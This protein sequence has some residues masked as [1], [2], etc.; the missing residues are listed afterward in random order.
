LKTVLFDATRESPKI[1]DGRD[2]T[3]RIVM[4][5]TMPSSPREPHRHT[6]RGVLALIATSSWLG[7]CMLGTRPETA[8]TSAPR[9]AKISVSYAVA[10]PEHAALA[11]QLRD[12]FHAR[13][14]QIE[15][16]EITALPADLNTKMLALV[17]AGTPPD[18]MHFSSGGVGGA[19]DLAARGALHPLDVLI[20]RDP[21]FSWD[22][23]WPGLGM[24]G[25]F[26]G[27][28]V[29]LPAI[30]L[31]AAMTFYNREVF[32]A[33]GRLTPD[34]HFT[35]GTWSWDTLIDESSKLTKRIETNSSGGLVHESGELVQ[36]GL[37]SPLEWDVHT[38]T[39]MLLRSYGA[40]FLSPDGAKVVTKTAEASQA[41]RVAHEL[42]YRRR[43][44]PGREEAKTL[45]LVRAGNL[46]Q[47]IYWSAATAWW[48][49]T[50]LD[51]DIAPVP[52]GP[53]RHASAATT[54]HLAL[55]R[56]TKA[57]DAAWRYAM[58]S[59]SPDADVE[60][61]SSL[62]L[63]T[64]RPTQFPAWRRR[65][66]AKKPRNIGLIELAARA[67]TVTPLQRPHPQAPAV[68]RLLAREM[69]ALLLDGKSPDQVADTL[70][71]EGNR[72]LALK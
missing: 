48:R 4:P 63:V 32:A 25:Q 51:W 33:A 1:L 29:A 72:L 9:P 56:D 15:L 61:A 60:R 5:T 3:G 62:G 58:V 49:T 12:Q 30:G 71:T 34:E 67:L 36:A 53:T 14:P 52:R 10:V 43:T 18:A 13:Y 7:G 68:E 26:E 46:A 22:D 20:K 6:R 2:D 57:L 44:M 37:G 35:R 59:L 42:G 41:L 40:D 28:Q 24:V 70:A 64:L 19:A 23:F 50:T 45:D 66:E 11:S 8:P 38:W 69:G 27:T 17:A 55:A 47:G 65:M 16:V 54:G 31:T 39:V 21:A